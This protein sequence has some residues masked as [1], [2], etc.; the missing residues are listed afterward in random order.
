MRQRLR[1]LQKPCCACLPAFSKPNGAFAKPNDV[2]AKPNDVFAKPN[3]AFVEPNDAFGSRMVLS[4][5]QMMFSHKNG[6]R[7]AN[8]RGAILLVMSRRNIL[9][10]LKRV[11]EAMLLRNFIAQGQTV[12]KYASLAADGLAAR[13]AYGCG[14]CRR[15]CSVLKTVRCR[16]GIANSIC[17]SAF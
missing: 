15:E 14:V 17:G 6:R 16:A 2:F 12:S 4:R 13:Q 10:G 7:C 1:A 8:L 3:D 9:H 11:G 5:S